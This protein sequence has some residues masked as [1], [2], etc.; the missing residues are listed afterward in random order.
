MIL[1]PK[2]CEICGETYTPVQRT[3]KYCPDCQ[4]D[5]VTAR[6]RLK[7]AK[8]RLD[9]TF[10]TVKD[11][12]HEWKCYECGRV[13]ISRF[14]RQFC[15]EA[16]TK[17]YND[18]ILRCNYCGKLLADAGIHFSTHTPKYSVY[19]SD[20]CKRQQEFKVARERGQTASCACCGVEFIAKTKRGPSGIMRQKYCSME[21]ARI[22]TPGTRTYFA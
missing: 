5:P 3:Q 19:C 12:I 21:C 15:S 17:T 20:E 7:S 2:K 14:S 18:R 11:N 16:C 6:R 22:V 1:E 10:G 13:M 9:Y 8:R 4:K